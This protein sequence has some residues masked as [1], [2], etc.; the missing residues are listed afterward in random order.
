MDSW[1]VRTVYG[2]SCAVSPVKP[3]MSYSMKSGSAR[4]SSVE[5]SGGP[6]SE[7]QFHVWAGGGIHAKGI[8]VE[9]LGPCKVRV[10]H[11]V[12]CNVVLLQ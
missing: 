9:E 11:K 8:Q 3:I 1:N 12:L 6:A 5:G 10:G 4:S 7:E 2:C